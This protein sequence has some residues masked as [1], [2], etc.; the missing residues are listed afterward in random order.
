[1]ADYQLRQN[2]IEQLRIGST[3]GTSGSRTAASLNSAFVKGTSGAAIG[4]RYKSRYATPINELYQFLDLTTGTRA[5]VSMVAKLWDVNA[6]GTQP[7]ATLLATSSSA[8]LPAADDRWIRFVFPSPYTPAIG[9]WVFFT[10]ENT[11][12]A[13]ATDFPG[14]LNSSAMNTGVTTGAFNGYSTANGFNTGGTSVGELPLV[15]LHNAGEVIGNPFLSA[16]T[17]GTFVGKRG[18]LLGEG[19]KG[20]KVDYWRTATS[21][22]A[23]RN[24][25]IYDLA[26]PPGGTPLLDYAVND[27]LDRAIGLARVG[28]DLSTLPGSGPFVMCVAL[29]STVSHGGMV[30]IEDYASYPAV[31]DAFSADNFAY[32]PYVYESAGNWVIDRSRIGGQYLE[33]RDTASGGGGGGIKM[34]PGLNG[35]FDG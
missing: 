8:S 11:A 24:V 27:V 34:F 18:V 5:N 4:I 9:E 2:A 16:G 31:F 32:N 30:L 10:V 20:Y 23:I 6:S 29:S 14:I 19:I 15:I 35:G 1:M 13:P 22:S 12:A 26:T 25:Q 17:V 33:I 7:G 21:S 3:W 28:W